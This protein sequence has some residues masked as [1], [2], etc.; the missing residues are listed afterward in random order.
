[1][2]EREA[3]ARAVELALRGWG[4][5]A[6]NPLV[7]AVLL[8]DGKIVGEGF[9]AEF[10]GAHAETS[11]LAKCADPSD[12]TCVVTLEPCSHRG[13]T[14]PCADALV[15]AK[16]RRVVAAVSEPTA[17]AGGGAERLRRA[18]V[19]VEIGVGS[20]E[21]AA[22]NAAFLWAEARP[23]R[24][25]VAL[26]LASSLDGF[27]ADQKGRSQWISA[28]VAQEYVQWLRAGFDA[29]AVGRG[30]AE[31]DDPELTVRG[32]PPRIP[33]ARVVFAGSGALRS[34]LRIVCTTSETPTVVVADRSQS[35]VLSEQLSGFGVRV[36]GASGLQDG[37]KQLRQQ[38]YRS[39]LVEG[40]GGL[41][42]SLLEA[43]LV[44]RLY[45]IQAPLWLGGGVPAF[46]SRT[47]VALDKAS[48]WTVV[49]RRALGPDTL[50]VVDQ[51]LCLAES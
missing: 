7:G 39:V 37:L 44:D 18:G 38:G 11:A 51:A 3:M 9:H 27:I 36:L 16:V 41:A 14:P 6:P 47:A 23:E 25:F 19:E 31:T 26:K 48:R 33:P 43:G 1:V 15:A 8:R 2:N 42:G 28:G 24:P 49:E 50:L 35:T 17:Q 32:A 5:V 34:D 10:G 20:A 30:T 21:A 4:R 22:L 45:W 29:I 12:T 40:G 46:G 13:K